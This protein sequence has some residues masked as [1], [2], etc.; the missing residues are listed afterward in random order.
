MRPRRSTALV[1]FWELL[2]LALLLLP[3]AVATGT[4][5][6]A[7]AV[8]AATKA[9]LIS[10][11]RLDGP[12][13]PTPNGSSEPHEAVVN[14]ACRA[15]VR[16]LRRR[17]RSRPRRPRRAGAGHR[18]AA[19]GGARGAEPGPGELP[20]GRGQDA[21]AGGRPRRRRTAGC[22]RGED[23][24]DR[25]Q[26]AR[27][28]DDRAGRAGDLRP[29]GG[30]HR[31]GS[32]PAGAGTVRGAGRRAAHAAALPLQAGGRRRTTRSR[33]S[34]PRAC[35]STTPAR[36]RCCWRPARTGGWSARRCGSR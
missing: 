13:R 23:G 36:G 27:V 26:P 28:R 25:R 20:A 16:R 2:L 10:S 33:R 11:L 15:R 29:D 6:S 17:L 34:T 8:H 14:R 19:R 3:D 1:S 31:A 30:V 35:A 24:D 22:A 7:A 32:E 5:S 21:A 12:W 18:R 4:A 9:L